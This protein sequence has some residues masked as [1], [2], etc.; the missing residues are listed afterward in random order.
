[1][2][3]VMKALSALVLTTAVVFAGKAEANTSLAF[4][5]GYRSD[6]LQWNHRVADDV[7]LNTKSKLNFKDLEIFQIGAKLKSTCGECVYYRIEGHYGWVLDGD[8]R[9][10]DQIAQKASSPLTTSTV[11]CVINP[12]LHNKVR[13][14]YTADF[15]IGFGYPLQ[16]CLCNGLQVI[17]TVGFEYDTIRLNG[18]N[19]ENIE[20]VVGD[21]VFRDFCLVACR[22]RHDECSS[23]SSSS[24]SSCPGNGGANKF[25]VTTWGPWIGF[26]L[27][28]CH[29]DCWNV[30]SEFQFQFA[31]TRRQRNTCSSG[32]EAIDRHRRTRTAFGYSL[33]IGSIYFIRCN[34]FLDGNIFWKHWY[35]DR[36]HD[37]LSWSQLGVGLGL[38][39]MF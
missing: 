13:N 11:T 33:K 37:H 39:Y 5:I 22:D 15:N 32:L 17:P 36:C 2:K 21:G 12:V 8:L 26:D 30:Y 3:H 35:S 27:A 9:E 23:S 25:R 28:Y 1:M 29:Q 6:D 18:K 34:W 14:K 31:R 7:R 20:N 4:D 19:R 38:G 16:W 10:S 24:S